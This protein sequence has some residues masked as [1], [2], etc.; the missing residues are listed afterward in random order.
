MIKI[1]ANFLD[2]SWIVLSKKNCFLLKVGF[3]ALL[4]I[5]FLT[6]IIMQR[7][8]A[9]SHSQPVIRVPLVVREGLSYGARV[10]YFF[11]GLFFIFSL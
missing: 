4:A 9:K 8:I 2:S 11:E 6:L 10:D 1:Y 5:L 7:G 3:V